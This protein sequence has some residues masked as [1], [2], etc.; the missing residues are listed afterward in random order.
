MAS[1]DTSLMHYDCI[2]SI[3]PVS[4]SYSYSGKVEFVGELYMAI[5]FLQTVSESFDYNC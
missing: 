2:Y 4:W 5:M 1:V 3:N